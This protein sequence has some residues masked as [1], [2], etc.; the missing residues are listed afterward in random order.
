MTTKFSGRARASGQIKKMNARTKR[1]LD[2][3]QKNM[4]DN[5]DVLDQLSDGFLADDAAPTA[6]DCVIDWFAASA[7]LWGNALDMYHEVVNTCLD[8][9]SS[10][11]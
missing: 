8:K 2:A 3:V 7:L 6:S 10:S 9:E 1:V 11:S 4:K 5:V